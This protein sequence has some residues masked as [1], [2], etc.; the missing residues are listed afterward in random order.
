MA[1]TKLQ[2]ANTNFLK[3]VL[4]RTSLWSSTLSTELGVEVNRRGSLMH[5]SSTYVFRLSSWTF[6]WLIFFPNTLFSPSINSG[7]HNQYVIRL[8]SV[9]PSLKRQWNHFGNVFS[10]LLCTKKENKIKSKDF[11]KTE[12]FWGFYEA[13]N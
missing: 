13:N 3:D 12:G 9:R 7:F 11:L 1:K 4:T 10:V 6:S 8:T 2:L 5:E